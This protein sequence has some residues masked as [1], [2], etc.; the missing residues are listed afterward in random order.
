MNFKVN[1]LQHIGIPTNKYEKT[2]EFYQTLGFTKVAAFKDPV[3][4]SD[5]TFLQNGPLVIET[6]NRAEDAGNIGAIDHLS[7]DTDD[8]ESCWN[9]AKK[10]GYTIIEPKIMSLP[11]WENGIRYFTVLGP[12][13]EK[14]E[15]CSKV[16]K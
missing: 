9:M 7:F 12:N 10:L 13:K 8:I 6:Y 16:K 3:S 5:V 2:V 14:I 4:K 15:F 11:F 1:G